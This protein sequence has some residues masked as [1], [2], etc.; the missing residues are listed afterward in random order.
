MTFIKILITWLCRELFRSPSYIKLICG[1]KLEDFQLEQDFTFYIWFDSFF[2]FCR[3]NI[4]FQTPTCHWH[5]GCQWTEALQFYNVFDNIFSLKN[6]DV[7]ILKLVSTFPFITG[8]M[9]GYFV[10]MRWKYTCKLYENI[11]VEI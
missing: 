4:Y 8:K 5:L 6:I 9:I 3:E 7:S 11:G 10:K 2:V 1:R